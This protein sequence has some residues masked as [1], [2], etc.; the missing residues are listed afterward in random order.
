MVT[1]KIELG[2]FKI[3]YIKRQSFGERDEL[4]LVV[5]KKNSNKVSLGG[6]SES[7]NAQCEIFKTF[8]E[9][10]LPF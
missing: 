2:I 6:N 10:L 1:P 4:T 7:L 5:S 9:H 3:D 8:D